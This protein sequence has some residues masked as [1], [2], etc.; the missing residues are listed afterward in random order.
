MKG[1][2]R[3]TL[4]RRVFFALVL[5]FVAV[6]SVLLAFEYVKF[7]Q[8]M[9]SNSGLH[10]LSRALAVALDGVDDADR[11]QSIVAAS[12]ISLNILR[13]EGG[14]LPGEVLFELE[15]RGGR[16]L[17]RAPA[18][19][20]QTLAGGLG[21]VR[22]QA[23]GD[24]VYWVIRRDTAR[25]S[26]RIAEP[27]LGDTTVLGW[28][29][30]ELLPYMLL[31][32]PFVLAP[33]WFAVRR[34]LRPL[35]MLTQRIEARAPDD[36]S[37]IGQQLKYAELQPMVA[38]FDNLLAQLRHQVQRERAF[39]Q[40]AAH[41]LRTP[42]AVIAAQAHV[43]VRAADSGE[44]QQAQGHLDQAIARASHLTGQLLELATL[45]EARPGVVTT[46]DVAHHL[47]HLL[48]QKATLAM[49][50]NI[51]LSLEAPDT[52]HW[53]LDMPA[54]Q[55]IIH[56]LLDNALRYVHQ[57]CRVAVA[58]SAAGGALT[59]SI[60]DDGP[61][62]AEDQRDLVFERFYRVSG[63]TAPG[64]GLGLAI[65]RQAARRMGGTVQISAGLDQRGCA[66]H[67][68]LGTAAG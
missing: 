46:V 62:I 32:F 28:L 42:M 12:A 26:L 4:T 33:L 50:R 44:R 48:A 19:G 38:A 47:R 21:Q 2:L 24:R 27:K 43:I 9:R 64:S 36:L 13:R 59:L 60:A 57:G 67:V 5:A 68:R 35:R 41:E 55:S 45:D 53:P 61:G 52:L 39:V 10:Q 66:F 63:N 30:G 29:G 3:P 18:L 54:F 56:N 8:Q 49:T 20:V 16:V 34:G 15:D 17:Y 37:P 7:Q 22:D 58:A 6:W 40:D 23:I 11:A 31:A 25:W 51:D 65:V 14:Q 1:W